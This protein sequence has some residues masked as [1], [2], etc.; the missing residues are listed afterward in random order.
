[1]AL[2]RTPSIL[3]RSS[4]MWFRLA[5]LYSPTALA[6]TIAL[7][8]SGRAFEGLLLRFPWDREE[9]PHV[10]IFAFRRK[11]CLLLMPRRAAPS[12]A[13]ISP[14]TTLSRTADLV[15]SFRLKKTSLLI[16][17]IE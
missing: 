12:A 17:H 3:S 2:I 6:H 10:R 5:P 4:D 15:A 9:M 13:V 16:I 11:I 1:L 7:V 8:S 14:F